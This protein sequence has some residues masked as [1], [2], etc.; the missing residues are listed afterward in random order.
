[1][2][3]HRRLPG[4]PIPMRGVQ[5]ETR[6]REVAG[7]RRDSVRVAAGLVPEQVREHV[8]D[9]LPRGLFAAGTYDREHGSLGPLQVAG[10]QL[11]P[12]EP[13]RAREE[14][15]AIGPSH[16]SRSIASDR[17][18]HVRRERVSAGVISSSM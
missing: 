5:A 4:Q 17:S 9:P 13:G 12:D 3:D 8:V 11:H 18:A 6:R 16:S 15:G 10:Q 1:M 7:D 14:H 2:D